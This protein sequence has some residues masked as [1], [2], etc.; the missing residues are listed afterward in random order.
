MK[1]PWSPGHLV[2]LHPLTPHRCLYRTS[3]AGWAGQGPAAPPRMRYGAKGRTWEWVITGE[4][5]RALTWGEG[6]RAEDGGCSL[7][8][9]PMC[10]VAGEILKAVRRS[11]WLRLGV[12][13]TPPSPVVGKPL[14][15]PR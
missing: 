11:Q 2:P 3:R 5:F 1:A 13:C 12:F 14:S 9:L 7:L 4:D 10:Q 8:L 15:I 6:R